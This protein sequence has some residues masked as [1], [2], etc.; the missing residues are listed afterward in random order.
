MEGLYARK[1]KDDERDCYE[2]CTNGLEEV[3][4]GGFG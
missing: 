4:V 2:G 1:S 3:E